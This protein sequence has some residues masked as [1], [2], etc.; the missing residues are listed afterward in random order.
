MIVSCK[1]FERFSEL[2][3]AAFLQVILT[4]GW[5]SA[6]N[7][8]ASPTLPPQ[9]PQSSAAPI[10]ASPSPAAP[11]PAATGDESA[12]RKAVEDHVRNNPGI[13]MSAMD[14]SVDGIKID[15]D[16]AQANATFRLKQGGTSMTMAYSLSRHAD[17]WLVVKNQP[18]D[19]QFVH[20]P[21]DKTH[22]G[23]TPDSTNPSFPDF[24]DFM[25]K[26]P[27]PNKN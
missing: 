23:A 4:L 7:K 27:P 9:Q 19:G 21:M 13:N 20:P 1:K 18:G 14:M 24:H 3:P 2:M 10:P 22:S 6:C 11:S 17:G 8:A 12:I 16:Q 5:A 25:K 26:Q 15:G